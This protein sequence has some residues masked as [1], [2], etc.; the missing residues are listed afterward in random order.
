M[1]RGSVDWARGRAEDTVHGGMG[2]TTRLAA[3]GKDELR[4]TEDGSA[5][6]S[7]MDG[8]R[9]GSFLEVPGKMTNIVLKAPSNEQAFMAADMGW[10]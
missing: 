4:G 8:S 7:G 2:Q 6:A 5:A 3:F 10:G 1:G 9:G